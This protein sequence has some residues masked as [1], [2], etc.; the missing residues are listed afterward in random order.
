MQY[1][2]SQRETGP[3]FSFWYCL[4]SLVLPKEEGEFP[5][6][7][8]W[9]QGEKKEISCLKVAPQWD[10]DQSHPKMEAESWW[11]ELPPEGEENPSFPPTGFF[12]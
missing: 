6:Q 12:S 5:R 2:S 3:T 4:L 8:L 9:T 7:S 11:R 1:V 10:L